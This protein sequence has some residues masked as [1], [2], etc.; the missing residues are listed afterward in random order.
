M[1]ELGTCAFEP[2]PAVMDLAAQLCHAPAPFSD[3]RLPKE[4]ELIPYGSTNLRI[5][6][7]PEA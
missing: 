7:F 2:P 6:E 3:A 4:I 5:S 1:S